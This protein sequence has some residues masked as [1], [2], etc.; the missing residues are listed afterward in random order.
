MRA[1][2][3]QAGAAPMALYNHF[4][5]KDALL[6]ALLDRVLGRVDGGPPTGDWI[7]DLRGFAAAH[8]RVLAAHAGAV[9]PLH[10]PDARAER[11]A[12]RRGRPSGS[13]TA[14]AS[15]ARPRSPGSARW[16]R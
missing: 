2:A 8:R 1:V 11:D 15:A 7:A 5:T 3:A 14:V 9:V 13:S 4:P 12:R 16:S 6:E 10:A